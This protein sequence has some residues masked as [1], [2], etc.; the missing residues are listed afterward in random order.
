MVLVPKT[1]LVAICG[2]LNSHVTRISKI[3]QSLVQRNQAVKLK[4]AKCKASTGCNHIGQAKHARD[5][6][7]CCDGR[8]PRTKRL[9]PLTHGKS[10]IQ[11]AAASRQILF[12][13][14]SFSG[15]LSV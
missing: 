9:A 11:G 7:D 13:H 15:P 5:F 6:S 14:F 3:S 8:L 1:W 4:L 2:L 10:S 12:L